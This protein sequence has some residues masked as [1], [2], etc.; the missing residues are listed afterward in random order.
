MLVFSSAVWAL[1]SNSDEPAVAVAH[2][3]SERLASI[4]AARANAGIFRS[5]GTCAAPTSGRFTDM[6]ITIAVSRAGYDSSFR[7]QI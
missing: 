7:S 4:S 2:S 6:W 5:F 3:P 1:A